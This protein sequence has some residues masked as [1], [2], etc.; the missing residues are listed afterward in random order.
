MSEQLPTPS[1]E[2]TQAGKPEK[3]ASAGWMSRQR[4]LVLGALIA[5]APLTL[6]APPAHAGPIG[7]AA[8]KA[9]N[10]AG[11]ALGGLA[12]WGGEKIKDLVKAGVTGLKEIFMDAL[13]WVGNGLNPK[14]KTELATLLALIL[15]EAEIAKAMTRKSG[16]IDSRKLNY[17]LLALTYPVNVGLARSVLGPNG[18]APWVWTL[19]SVTIVI[20]KLVDIVKIYQRGGRRAEILAYLIEDDEAGLTG[21]RLGKNKGKRLEECGYCGTERGRLPFCIDCGEE[22]PKRSLKGQKKEPWESL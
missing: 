22:H 3:P 11:D 7:D 12:G 16:G 9:A 1:A 2:M 4:G 8:G 6:A 21:E 5:A 19:A 15:L 17:M 10:A 20:P 14:D 13:R 18:Y